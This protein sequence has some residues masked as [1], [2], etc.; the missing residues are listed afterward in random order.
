MKQIVFNDPF[1]KK[2]VQSLDFDQMICIENIFKIQCSENSAENIINKEIIEFV[3]EMTKLLKQKFSSYKSQ[4]KQSHKFDPVQHITYEQMIEKIYVS[5]LKCYYCC[6]ELSI[7][8]NRKRLKSQW[9]LERLNNNLG[10]YDTNT[11]ICCL[12]CNLKRR[13]E[14][15]E[16]FK[17]SKQ[18][19]IKLER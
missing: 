18:T 2:R 10:H 9:T 17:K 15:H 11:C 4:D 19:I 7:I 3:K 5:K 12:D 6:C 13:T 1:N 8:Y 14:N 16:Y